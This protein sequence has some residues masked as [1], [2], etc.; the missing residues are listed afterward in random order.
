MVWELVIDCSDPDRLS[1]FWC[2]ALNYRRSGQVGQY[3]SIVP[4]GKVPE[5]KIIFQTVPESKRAKDRLHIDVVVT[6]IEIE[7]QRLIALGAER[8]DAEPV[9]EFGIAWIR[10]RDP[11]GNEFCVCP[12]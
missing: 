5:P 11:E 3:R 8:A 10:M 9:R 7:C 2:G 12:K 6:D 4:A 1:D